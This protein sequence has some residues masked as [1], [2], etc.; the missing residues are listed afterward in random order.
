MLFK[1]VLLVTLNGN[2]ANYV[3]E[4]N[5]TREACI[6]QMLEMNHSFKSKSFECHGDD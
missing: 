2:T 1:L 6:T 3:I 4:E 5:L